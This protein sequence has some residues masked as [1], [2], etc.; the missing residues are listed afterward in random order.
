M[1]NFKFLFTVLLGCLI[2]ITMISESKAQ[3]YTYVTNV[4][5]NNISGIKT[6]GNTISSNTKVDLIKRIRCATPEVSSDQ[7]ALIREQ[8]RQWLSGHQ[9]QSDGMTTTIPV[10]F[11]VVRHDDGTAGVS[12]QQIDDQMLVLNQAFNGTNFQFSLA[13]VDYT[14]NTQWSTHSPGTL[15]ESEMKTALAVDP[16]HTLNFYTCDIGGGLLGYATFPW[17]YPEDNKMH[18]VVV[19]YAS[20]PGGSAVP[21]DLGDTGTHEVGHYLGLYHTFQGGCN[22]PGDEVDDTPYESN[23]AFGCPNGLDTCPADGL[24]PIHNFM[25]YTDDDCMDHFT[26]GQSD[27]MD[28]MM[29]AY[30]PSM[31]NGGAT[32]VS[33]ELFTVD[34][35]KIEIDNF[36]IEGNFTLGSSSNG[37]DPLTEDVTLEVGSFAVTIPAGS[38][39][40][41][42][43]G[44]EFEGD[45][46]A[47][48]VK[49]EIHTL[50]E[51]NYYFEA[52]F[53]GVDLS[54]T[55]FPVDVTLT[56]G[57]DSGTTSFS[58]EL[59][60]NGF[61]KQGSEL[62][63]DFVLDQ[64]YPNPFNPATQIR[65]GLPE[66]GNVTLKIYN[67][68]GQLVKTLVNGNMSEG[69]HQVNWDATNS[70]GSKLSSGIYFYTL[71]SGSFI[72]S[73]KMILMK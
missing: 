20:L 16:I 56:I 60:K 4:S 40:S 49:F 41:G 63:G 17:W 44:Y 38:F 51:G 50:G 73:K 64:N 33:F 21:Y 34:E 58:G 35:L 72:E 13:S 32:V 65:F 70:S 69:Y 3:T 22:V 71:T 48:G 5:S 19:L 10:A 43:K 29:A 28:V 23:P 52:D 15:A 39:E 18:G 54:G 27:R 11:H 36:K 30:R 55:T 6:G 7:Q 57:D 14:N 25:D 53:E 2:N 37:I 68:V 1:K 24:D 31:V 61:S 26:A 47:V 67:S 9:V 59:N 46:N 12:Q 8:V 45:I 42:K 66:A 62:P